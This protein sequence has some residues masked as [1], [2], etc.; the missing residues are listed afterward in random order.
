MRVSRVVKTHEEIKADMIAAD[1]DADGI[2]RAMEEMRH[3]QRE[4]QK[5]Y[6]SGVASKFHKHL[7][8]QNSGG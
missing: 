6:D 8:A 1:V 3:A 4:A 5:A 2:D 7:Q